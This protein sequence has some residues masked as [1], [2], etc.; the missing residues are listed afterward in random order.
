VEGYKNLREQILKEFG[1]TSDS[2]IAERMV[3]ASLLVPATA[4]EMRRISAMADVAGD[5]NTNGNNWGYNFLAKGLAKYRQGNDEDA[6]QLLQRIL[7]EDIGS[8]RRAEAYFILAMAQFRLNQLDA[9]RASFAK[10]MEVA[11]GLPKSGDLSDDWNDWVVIH[12]LMRE[13]VALNPSFGNSISATA[14]DEVP[15]WL[16]ALTK[17]GWKIKSDKQDNGTWEI[18][19]E[20]QPVTDI[21]ALRGAPI[22]ELSLMRTAVSNLEPLRG[23]PLKKLW[24][25][26]TKVTDLSP[27]KGMPLTYLQISGTAATNLGPLREMPLH[28]LR[29]GGCTNITDLG[30]IAG[31]M[32]LQ[33]VILP[34]NAKSLEFLRGLTNLTRISFRY[35]STLKG[36]AQSAAEFW[37]DYDKNRNQDKTH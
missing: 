6:I 17:A 36:P 35:D 23:M 33:S 10:A 5:V 22:C 14:H 19:L 30:P 9:S 28:D 16:E 1:N 27:L 15:S 2:R 24:L 32:T 34:P 37:A 4:D 26:S 12:V 25:A 11:N 7:P 21:S 18:D 29:M 8:R 3:K 20:D 31:L 13:A